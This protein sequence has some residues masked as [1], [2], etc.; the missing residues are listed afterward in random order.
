VPTGSVPA[1]SQA[2]WLRAA[3]AAI[4][5]ADLRT[6]AEAA[7]RALVW[8]LARWAD[9][10]RPLLSRPTWPVLMEHTNRR[11]SWL[12]ARLGWLRERGLLGTVEHGST[13]ATRPL[14]LAGLAG[15]RAAVYLLCTPA[16]PAE[17]APA[18]PA[19]APE[20][21]TDPLPVEEDW[22]PPSSCKE[23]DQPL[24]A[25][26]GAEISSLR[27]P[28]AKPAPTG[29]SRRPVRPGTARSGRLEAAGALQRV[30]PAARRCSAA[31][32][33]ALIRVFLV[34]G[35]TTG[36]LV[37]ALDH[38]PDGVARWYTE[39]VRSPAGWL[40]TRLAPWLDGEGHPRPAHSAELAAVAAEHRR[41]LAAQRAAADAGAAAAASPSQRQAY[42]AA[43]RVTLAARRRSA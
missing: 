31:Q 8:C 25:R 22:T 33:A 36:D 16:P 4:D 43:I 41:R 38:G 26:A 42:L 21:I 3:T 1:R 37:Y 13:P 32:V 2:G 39:P 23:L 35:W 20:M 29:T 14:P 15:N 12:A 7:L 11:R 24:R 18:G 40:R 27:S 17:P 19:A 6:D 5:D 30:C 34:A 10:S 9:W 28:G